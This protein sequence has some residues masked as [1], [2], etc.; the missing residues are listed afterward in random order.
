MKPIFR[1]G[2]PTGPSVRVLMDMFGNLP[3]GTSV[4]Y[5]D[6]ARLINE[7]TGTARF[8]LVVSTWRKALRNERNQE[9]VRE[10]GSKCVRFL[11]EN[12]RA[13]DAARKLR[14]GIRITGRAH[15]KATAIRTEL[16][17]D[18]ERKTALHILRVTTDLSNMGRVATKEISSV[19]APQPQLPKNTPPKRRE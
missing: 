7:P 14:S 13:K 1:G 16:L 3:Q 9:T 6:I 17:T 19:Y 8:E 5:D 18:T 11:F 10:L 15:K 12:E 4:S 2:R